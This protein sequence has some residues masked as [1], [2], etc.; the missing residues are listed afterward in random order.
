MIQI[1]WMPRARKNRQ[2]AI[3][4][5]AQENLQAALDQLDQI[6]RQVDLLPNNPEIGRTGRKHGTRELML[7]KTSFILLY[8]IRPHAKRIEILRVLHTS[9]ISPI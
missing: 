6:E 7:S 8:R 5:I 4:Y 1:V 9:Q 2:A 3:E